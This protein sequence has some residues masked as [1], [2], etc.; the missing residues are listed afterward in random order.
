MS[1]ELR[2]PTGLDKRRAKLHDACVQDLR[3]VDSVSEEERTAILKRVARNMIKLRSLY[4][5]EDGLPDWKGVTYAYRQEVRDIYSE[6]G[7]P[8][9]NNHPVKA[10]LRYHVGNA[11]RTELTADELAEAGL[12]AN[13]PRERQAWKYKEGANLAEFAKHLTYRMVRTPSEPA[14]DAT[15]EH[16]RELYDRLGQW[17]RRQEHSSEA[18]PE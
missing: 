10:T 5:T 11:L 8:P 18:E 2:P 3:R 16:A 4:T 13:A 14:D 17:L 1:T 9:T 15:L 6:A 12:L 7:L